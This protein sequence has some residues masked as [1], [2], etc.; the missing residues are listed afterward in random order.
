MQWSVVEVQTF[1]YHWARSR[2]LFIFQLRHLLIGR[3]HKSALVPATA[4]N[5][6]NH[7]KL[8]GILLSVSVLV[9]GCLP[10]SLSASLFLSAYILPQ[11]FM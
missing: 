7:R 5:Q 9:L 11:E 6:N 4:R 10:P 8:K 1:C 3:G 2:I